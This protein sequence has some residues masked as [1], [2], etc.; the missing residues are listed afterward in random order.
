MPTWCRITPPQTGD[1]EVSSAPAGAAVYVDNQ[2]KGTTSQGNT[3]DILDLSVG[4]HT[5][6]LVKAGY[7]DFTSST[8]IQNGQTTSLYATLV[9]AGQDTHEGQHPGQ[10]RPERGRCDN[11]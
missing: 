8:V 11:Q 1:L 2:Y 10:F 5:V 4:S 3:L 9:P 6:K 7:Q